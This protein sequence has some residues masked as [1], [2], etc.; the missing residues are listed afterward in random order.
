MS[1]QKQGMDR[2]LQNRFGSHV[3]FWSIFLLFSTFI[4]TLSDG[5]FQDHLIKYLAILPS[6][7][8]ATYLLIYVQISKLLLKKHYVLFA[9]SIVVMGYVFSA[10]ARFNVVHIAEPFFR[11]DFQQ[12]TIAEIVSDVYYLFTVYFPSIYTVAFL[13]LIIHNVKQRIEER[14]QIERL[15]KEKAMN[16]LKFLKAQMQ[17]HF[18]FNTLNNLYALTL[19][20]SDLAPEVVL[21]LSELLDFILYQSHQSEISLEKEIELIQ[22]FVDL[23]GL[24]YGEQ[25]D[26]DVCYDIQDASVAIAPLMLLPFVENAFKHGVSG[27]MENP[28]IRIKLKAT[29]ERLEFSVYNHKS[30]SKGISKTFVQGGIGIQNL[31]RQLELNYPKRHQ[32]DIQETEDDY[33]IHLTLELKADAK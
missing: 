24:R 5:K 4:A 6:Q 3:L 7:I 13:M 19:A 9:I 16:E 12:E 11:T 10:L 26:M 27:N 32:L 15:Q 1:L 18:L 21:K 17:P 25:I 23:E 14:Q 22:G 2:M 33:T 28:V 8:L 31:Q 29:Q 30:K 20:K